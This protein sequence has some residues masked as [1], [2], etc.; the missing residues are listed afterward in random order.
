MTGDSSSDVDG[1]SAD[2]LGLE[3]EALVKRYREVREIT[4]GDDFKSCDAC[5]RTPQTVGVI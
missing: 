2:A 1:V 5:V 3:N 4:D